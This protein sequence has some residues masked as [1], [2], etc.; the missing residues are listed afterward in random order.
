MSET[1][2]CPQCGELLEIP[3][4]LLDRPVRCGACQRV[5]SPREPSAAEFDA[6]P[7]AGPRRRSDEQES[8][9]A[10]ARRVIIIV[11]LV[12]GFLGVACCGGFAFLIYKVM[13]PKMV[14]FESDKGEYTASFPGQP[15]TGSTRLTGRGDELSVYDSA[16]RPMIQE[17]FSIAYVPL[18]EKD[19]SK[20]SESLLN[21]FADGLLLQ[22]AGSAECRPRVV[23]TYDG[24]DAMDV[25][26][27]LDDGRYLQ[28]RIVLA[29]GKAYIVSVTGPGQPDGLPWVQQFLDSFKP[30][31]KLPPGANPFRGK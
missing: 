3:K 4:A 16:S 2:S 27:E 13:N 15:T 20:R 19:K 8:P 24:H 31:R 29:N 30:K 14:P 26:L 7:A 18:T 10:F 22:N 5:F 12:V 9:N 17:E 6:E 25:C 21:E 23:R 11:M 28:G 1:H